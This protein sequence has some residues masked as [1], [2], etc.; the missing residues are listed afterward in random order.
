[1]GFRHLGFR[2]LSAA[3]LCAAI[4]A[5]ALAGCVS[6]DT[7]V[8][9]DT[10][11][12]D[13]TAVV[14]AEQL[15]LNYFQFY[16]SHNSYKTAIPAAG[17][18]QLRAV[19]PQAALALEYWHAPIASQLDAGL[20]VLE[21]DVFYDP[22][23]RLFK[24]GS[25][26]PV[27][28]VQNIDTGSHCINLGECLA[29]VVD[30][31]LANPDHE[32]LMISFN[33][34]TDV[35]DQPGFIRPNEFDATAWQ[36]FDGVLRESLG[37]R[38]INPAEVLAP[39]GPQWP[40]LGEARGRVLLLLDEGPAKHTAYLA[41]V[42]KPALFANLPADDP[43]AA[44]RVIND[45]VAGAKDIARALRRGMLVRTRA[46]ADTAEARTGST[47]RRDAAFASGAQFISTDYYLMASHFGTNYQVLL[48]GGGA[49]RCN[50]EVTHRAC[51]K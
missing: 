3:L 31:S 35:I 36:A 21:F 24:R 12:A 10:S 18:A 6:V 4:C 30:W 8:S 38:V 42:A 9:R 45:P 28:H 43:R 1:V 14:S 34:K 37:A 41:A 23:Q 15:P 32:P 19:N 51:K 13:L 29:S 20:R 5:A 26:F 2:N 16:G 27:L 22:Q 46:D 48:P 25:D 44:I 47:T 40:A 33:A 49:I 17:L 11:A 50:P 7:N 39:G